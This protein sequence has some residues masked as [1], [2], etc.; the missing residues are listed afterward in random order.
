MSW[1]VNGRVRETK[2]ERGDR[3]DREGDRARERQRRERGREWE[4]EREKE[5][6][7]R[8]QGRGRVTFGQG[9][10]LHMDNWG[11]HMW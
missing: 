11:W 7:E 6:E 9:I 8:E 1:L 4:R 10:S 3:K 2:R 5:R